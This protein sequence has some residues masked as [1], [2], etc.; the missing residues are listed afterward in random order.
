MRDFAYAGGNTGMDDTVNFPST[1]LVVRY[2]TSGVRV[3]V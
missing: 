3:G 1:L 2:M